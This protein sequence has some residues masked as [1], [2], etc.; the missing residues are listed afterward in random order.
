MRQSDVFI[1]HAFYSWD[2]NKLFLFVY[3]FADIS[4]TKTVQFKKFGKLISSTYWNS[5]SLCLF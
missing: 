4:L 3:Y 2:I 5:E 1:N